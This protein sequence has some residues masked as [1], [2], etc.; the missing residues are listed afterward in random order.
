MTESDWLTCAHPRP[1]LAHL[2]R[3]RLADGRRLRLFACACVRLG[4]WHLLADPRSRQAVEVA[5]AFADGLADEGERARAADAAA[6]AT[7]GIADAWEAAQD[8]ASASFADAFQDQADAAAYAALYSCAPAQGRG[9]GAYPFDFVADA[10]A[11][12]AGPEVRA[13]QAD[14]VR[15][16]FGDPFRGRAV[17][18]RAGGVVARLAGAAHDARLPSG[19]LEPHRLAVLADALEDAGC[20][21]AE[22]LAHLRGPGPHA[23]GCWALDA[24]LG[25]T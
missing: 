8:E 6:A 18:A 12:A 15:D 23:L 1:M 5:E 20:G 17:A 2:R 14:L 25:K 11:F 7:V 24:L 4:A 22:L 16:I 9:A 21:Q 3:E 10:V 19:E 13:R